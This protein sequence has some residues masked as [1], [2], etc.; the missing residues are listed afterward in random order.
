MQRIDSAAAAT[1]ASLAGKLQAGVTTAAALQHATQQHSAPAHRTVIK[2]G[3]RA[4]PLA[5]CPKPA[6]AVLHPPVDR[7]T[8][9]AAATD[10]QCIL[11]RHG[12]QQLAAVQRWRWHR[13]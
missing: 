1:A 10:E 12:H 9:R 6:P 2:N 13:T 3:R 11:L 4:A 8:A 5:R 7:A